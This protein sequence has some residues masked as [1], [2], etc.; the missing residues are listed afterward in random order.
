MINNYNWKS[1]QSGSFEA[2]AKG[3]G[4]SLRVKRGENEAFKR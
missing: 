1:P 3:C 2:S 4:N